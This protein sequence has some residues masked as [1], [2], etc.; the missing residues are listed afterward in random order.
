MAHIAPGG[1]RHFTILEVETRP[2]KKFHVA[3][4]VEM[5]VSDDDLFYLGRID[6]Q[7]LQTIGRRTQQLT[8]AL[9]RFLFV[10]TG[11]DE[12]RALC[13]ANEPDKIVQCSVSLV[14][15]T[16]DVVFGRGAGD[17]GIFDRINLKWYWINKKWSGIHIGLPKLV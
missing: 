3:P 9:A 11:I 4:M 1:I 6:A 10:K 2:W 16:A 17:C 7:Q 14:R 5:Q 13:I 8:T 12:K 15:I